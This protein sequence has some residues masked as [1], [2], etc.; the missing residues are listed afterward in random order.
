MDR[1]R[2]SVCMFSSN[3]FTAS[4]L[5]VDILSS[6]SSSSSSVKT[7][8]HTWNRR[9]TP[10][11]NGLHLFAYSGGYNS[12]KRP[13]TTERHL[14]PAV[15]C[16]PA[17][18]CRLSSQAV[19]RGFVTHHCSLKYHL[20]CHSPSEIF[21]QFQ[22]R[23]SRHPAVTI[24]SYASFPQCFGPQWHVIWTSVN[25]SGVQTK[26]NGAI[27]WSESSNCRI[28]VVHGQ[29]WIARRQLTSSQPLSHHT[30]LC[31]KRNHVRMECVSARYEFHVGVS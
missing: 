13:L 23:G 11:H 24:A 2:R 5:L 29:T 20:S 14:C 12:H 22:R 27:Y 16:D 26:G 6:S 3:F 28:E 7:R 18:L 19:D 8:S 21:G 10:R 15:G 17:H 31:I 30:Q 9:T 1:E 4:G 25:S